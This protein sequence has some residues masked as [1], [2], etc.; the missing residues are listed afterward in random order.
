MIWNRE[1]EC[2][3]REELEEIQL[4]RLQDTVR[5]AYENVPYYHEAFEK[6]GVYPEDI[7][8]L[9]DITRLPYTTKD[10][11]RKVYPSGCSLSPG[12]R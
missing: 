2:I 3:S 1:M 5:R 8:S 9:D 6:E 12:R 7:E 4:K 11:L 10:D